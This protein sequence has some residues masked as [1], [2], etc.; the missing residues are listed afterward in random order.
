MISAAQGDALARMVDVVGPEHALA[1]PPAQAAYLHE[2]RGLYTGAAALVLRPKSTA[3]V[4]ALLSIANGAGIGVVPQGGNTGLVGGQIPKRLGDDDRPQ[5]VLSLSRLNRVRCI[6]ADGG[7]M[8]VEAGVTLAQAQT[9][10]DNAG[11]LFPLSLAS[12]DGCQIGG[13]LATNAGGVGVLAYGNARA[14]ALGLEV[15]TADGRVWEGL[16]TL[17]KDNTGYDLRDLFIGSEG[18]LGVI[19]AAALKLFP[20]PAETA[21]AFAALPDLQS[22]GALFSLAEARA[23]SG[24][25]AFEFMSAFTLD[26]VTRHVPGNSMPVKTAA[27]WYVLIELSSHEAGSHANDRMERLLSEAIARGIVRDA[28]VA[29]SLAQQKALWH[30]RES[31]SEAQR[32]EGGSIKHDVS[33]PVA[34][35]AEF[36]AKANATVERICPDARPVVFG[37]FGDGNVHYNVTQPAAMDKQ[38]FLELWGKMTGAVHEVIASLD[39]SISAEHG[40]GQMKRDDLRRF[41]SALEIELMQ[42]IKDALDPNGILNPGKVL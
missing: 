12:E 38:T 39:G 17:K 22:V 16:R 1:D 35:I 29:T 5:V 14:L 15:V 7:T 10:A 19:T 42:R 28:T 6:D 25:T 23:H 27:P 41:K 9:A 26:L 24:L 13:V 4:S 31:A 30:L 32:G 11:R 2:L 21:V 37:H 3:E 36:V 18:T 34:R 20:R 8:I 33:V 40:I